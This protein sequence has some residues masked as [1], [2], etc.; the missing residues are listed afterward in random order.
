MNTN[1][2]PVTI[3]KPVTEMLLHWV[4][5]DAAND[6]DKQLLIES[7][8]DNPEQASAFGISFKTV[9]AYVETSSR[10]LQTVYP[11]CVHYFSKSFTPDALIKILW[12]IWIPLSLQLVACKQ[13]M[14]RPL[15]Q[16]VLGGQGAGKTTLSAAL[17][18]ILGSLGYRT[19]SLS[20]DDLY[21][22][23]ADR[24]QLK[25][26]DS[27]FIWRGPP[28]THDVDLGVK[29][30]QDFITQASQPLEIP[31][32]DKSLWQGEGDRI[33]ADIIEETVDFVLFEGWFVGVRPVDNAV[34][35][36]PPHPIQTDSDRTFAQDMN[37]QLQRYLPLWD[38]LDR[39]MVLYL[40]DYRLSKQWRK[41]AEHQMIAQGKQGMTDGEIDAFVEY[42][43]RSLH[44]ELFITP[45]TQRPDLVD[46]VIEINPDHSPGKVYAP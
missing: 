10:L 35:L 27:R 25:A 28:G 1:N 21:K 36:E 23:Y 40:P 45:L 44:P 30:L 13:G 11:S 42:F 38:Y 37:H 16:G 12:E 26:I 9:D 46:L 19:V 29:T 24:T 18:L 14:T 43:W 39:L 34:F 31:R 20:L 5:V 22:T 3:T 32:F 2:L 41:Q 6:L 4:T 17:T 7:I 15:I 33:A 8:L